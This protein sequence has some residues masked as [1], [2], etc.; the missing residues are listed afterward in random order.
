[1]CS[2]Q[3]IGEVGCLALVR[4]R[5]GTNH[6]TMLCM[7]DDASRVVMRHRRIECLLGSCKSVDVAG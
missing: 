1:M 4:D 6:M 3:A 7:G 2:L 5:F